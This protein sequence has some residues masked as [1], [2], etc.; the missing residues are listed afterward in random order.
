MLKMGSESPS[1][2]NGMPCRT[3]VGTILLWGIM[4]PEE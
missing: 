3:R 1:C 4:F 2:S